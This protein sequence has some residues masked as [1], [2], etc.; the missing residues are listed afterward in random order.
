LIDSRLECVLEALFIIS[1]AAL[2]LLPQMLFMLSTGKKLLSSV[3]A[4]LGVCGMEDMT[5]S[6]AYDAELS[7]DISE[8][9]RTVFMVSEKVV[10]LIC[11]SSSLSSR[12]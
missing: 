3:V 5:G 8:R 11:A 9:D 2:L 10:V 1:L 12:S 7:K 6:P 4:L